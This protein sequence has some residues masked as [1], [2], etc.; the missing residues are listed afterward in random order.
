MFLRPKVLEWSGDVLDC[1]ALQVKQAYS[2]TRDLEL[3]KPG[4]QSY[5]QVNKENY[6]RCLVGEQ[7]IVGVIWSQHIW[8]PW[9]SP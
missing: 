2:Y 9:T 4:N 1:Y 8:G 5:D 7:L 6:V 3:P